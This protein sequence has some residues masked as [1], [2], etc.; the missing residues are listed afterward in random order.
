M[1]RY[2]VLLYVFF[3]VGAAAQDD[4]FGD[5]TVDVEQELDEDRAWDVTGWVRQK[6][7]Y[8]FNQPDDRFSR[9][10][11]DW[12]SMQT[13]VFGRLDWQAGDN[14]ALRIS[15]NAIGDVIYRV[16]GDD[17]FSAEEVDEFETRFEWRDV[18]I[19][20]NVSN[21]AYVKIGR[22]IVAWGE[23]E[24]LRIVDLV[25]TQDQ[26]TFGQQDLENLRIPVPA[27]RVN[28][29]VGDVL[30]DGVVTYKA[31]RDDIAPAGDE[32]DRFIDL[33]ATG[34]RLVIDRPDKEMEALL[35]L[36]G[37]YG[38]G[39]WSVVGARVNANQLDARQIQLANIGMGN[40][41]IEEVRLNQDRFSALGVGINW[42]GG[43][44]LAF[45]EMGLHR[46]KR[47]QPADD[48]LLNFTEG[49]PEK[50]Q[51]LSAVGL[52]YS[53]WRNTTLTAEAD[54]I[55]IAEHEDFLAE[56]RRQLGYSARL[57]W[58]GL[59]ERV[60]AIAVATQLPDQQ[61]RVWRL[62]LDYDW[63]DSIELGLLW[64]NYSAQPGAALYNYRHNDTVQFQF[65]YSFQR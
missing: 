4:F 48:A 46:G 9:N 22:Q 51:W 21:D 39:D 27:L 19:E 23:A 15:A 53:G 61:G 40:V 64:V 33:R 12:S 65:E 7:A 35:R 1:Y 44:W 26:Y 58:T 57:R 31:G 17:N 5:I 24:N 41:L 32:F 60:Q 20:S 6:A 16:K 18:Y 63:S 28:Y 56:D 36:S 25:N 8:G 2:I 34:A 13:D 10:R 50:D 47:L 59:N 49:W 45:A 62:T 52:E 54:Y 3:A 38:S 14:T 37:H 11:R 55:L 42:T 43:A 30:V 29:S